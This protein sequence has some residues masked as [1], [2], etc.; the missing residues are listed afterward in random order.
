MLNYFDR[1]INPTLLLS[2]AVSFILI[3]GAELISGVAFFPESAI[4]HVI[5]VIFVAIIV[6]RIFSEYAYKDPI[7]RA[8]SKIEIGSIL[9]LGL[10]HV[11]EYLGLSILSIQSKTVHLSVLVGYVVWFLGNIAAM[12]FMLRTYYKKSKIWSRII[13]L[14]ILFTGVF[15]VWLNFS[16]S[17]TMSLPIWI[18]SAALTSVVVL[19]IVGLLALWTLKKILPIFENFAR[20]A[21]PG[22]I[23]VVFASFFQ[24]TESMT[25]MSSSNVSPAQDMYLAHFVL[26]SALCLLLIAVEKFKRPT[27][28]YAEE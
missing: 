20:Y 24:Y 19:S 14:L 27:G 3:A 11:Y 1:L 9:F 18:P 4:I 28:I 6:L 7:L 16:N 5:V 26:F 23:L 13:Y 10:I 8:F 17:T 2:L 12:E 15:L 22:T 21:I 25:A